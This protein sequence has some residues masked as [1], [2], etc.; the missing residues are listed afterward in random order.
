MD[1]LEAIALGVVA[2]ACVAAVFIAAPNVRNPRLGLGG[3]FVSLLALLALLGT[4]AAVTYY[5]FLT[6]TP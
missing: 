5:Q 4:A 6:P 1:P 2:L 3:R